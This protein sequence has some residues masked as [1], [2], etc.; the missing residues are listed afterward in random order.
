ME[1]PK[2]IRRTPPKNLGL[3]ELIRAK[4]EWNW[5]P[6]AEESKQ[7]FR[8]WHQRGYLPHFDA[9]D[10]TQFI[11]FQLYDS[12]PATRRAEFEAILK[13]PDDS[14]KRRMLETW[15]DRGHGECWLRRCD[16]A[17]AVEKILLEDDGRDYRIQAWVI[18]PNNVH[19]A[20]DIW[21]VPLVKLINGWKGKSSREANKLLRRRGAFWQEDYYDTLIR[22]EAHLKRAVRYTEQNPVKA[23]LTKSARDWPCTSARHRDEYERLPWQRGE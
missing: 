9:P 20:V 8:G 17:E 13:E 6:S 1:S 11:T 15:L 21:D 19:L 12:F 10:V 2:P 14:V 22:D 4:R 7:G 5:K 23:F 18:M 3:L 16:V